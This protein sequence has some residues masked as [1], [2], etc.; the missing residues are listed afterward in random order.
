M[1]GEL[2]APEPL[3]FRTEENVQLQYQLTYSVLKIWLSCH[4]PS[5]ISATCHP[6]SRTYHFAPSLE[7][8]LPSTTQLR[9]P[10]MTETPIDKA[11][12]RLLPGKFAAIEAKSQ[13]IE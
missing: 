5:Q 9:Q 1:E 13:S 7:I 6:V 4:L 8:K 2:V 12:E 3:V 11:T 10:I